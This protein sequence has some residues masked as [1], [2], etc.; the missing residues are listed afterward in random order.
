MIDYTLL[1]KHFIY[2]INII[3]VNLY[4][5]N[6]IQYLY[7]VLCYNID[8]FIEKYSYDKRLKIIISKTND[9]RLNDFVIKILEKHFP[10]NSSFPIAMYIEKENKYK[11]ISFL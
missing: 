11:G 9:D 10:R 2:E 5:E 1:D 3:S 6:D 8:K 4:D 7:G